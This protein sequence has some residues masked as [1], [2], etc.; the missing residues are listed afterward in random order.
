[1]KINSEEAANLNITLQHIIIM[2]YAFMCVFAVI[3]M[4][5][6]HIIITCNTQLCTTCIYLLYVHAMYIIA[7]KLLYAS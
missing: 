5:W 4:V 2:Q 3:N 6:L 1:M 7:R